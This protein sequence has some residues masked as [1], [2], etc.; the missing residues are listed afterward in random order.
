MF[1][2]MR[3]LRAVA[4]ARS[5]LAVSER[6]ALPT[7]LV[8]LAALA[9]PASAGHAQALSASEVRRLEDIVG[10][11]PSVR[12]FCAPCGDTLWREDPV[13]AVRAV[14]SNPP[15]DEW[16]LLVNGEPVDAA[17]LY[18]KRAEGW[19]NA[20]ALAGIAFPDVPATLGEA[21][22]EAGQPLPDS[23]FAVFSWSGLYECEDKVLKP[24]TRH[25]ATLTYALRIRD[26][27]DSL[28]ASLSVDG[29]DISHRMAL[30]AAAGGDS[31][32]L[33]LA[34]YLKENYGRPYAPGKWLF[35]LKRTPGG[36]LSTLWGGIVPGDSA[37]AG[38]GFRRI[39][40]D[41]RESPE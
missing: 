36:S 30:A 13:R 31:L 4:F 3:G 8:L 2:S 39:A 10:A 24:G 23:N 38:D 1:A 27:G 18:L 34:G 22:R 40:V 32:R 41:P 20:A 29:P 9:P 26:A 15:A 33:S 14:R 35:T 17:Y 16:T 5:G 21:L 12:H 19:E 6:P 7:L 11:S 37:A 28:K 25:P